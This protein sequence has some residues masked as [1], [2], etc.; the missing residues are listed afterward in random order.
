MGA[1]EAAVD[2]VRKLLAL[3]ESSNANEAAAAAAA[4]QRLMEQHGIDAAML[5]TEDEPD[6]PVAEHHIGDE[7]KRVATWRN[8][9]AYALARANGCKSI[10]RKQQRGPTKLVLIGRAS[11]A[12]VVRYMYRYLTNE[13]DRLCEAEARSRGRAGKTWRT[14]FR[15]GA[16]DV[17]TRRLDEAKRQARQERRMQA[18][19]GV[20]L[21]RV[22]EAI[23]KLDQRLTDAE[24][25]AQ[26]NLR[27]RK[28]SKSRWRNDP[29]AYAAGRKAGEQV[30]LDAGGPGLPS[31]GS[32]GGALPR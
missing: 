21:A 23:A 1:P 5:D 13:I 31:K 10:L 11:D 8:A 6:E 30:R 19:G 29:E 32:G 9:L 27:L 3:S 16:V 26:H 18:G 24:R 28:G 12:A 14:N 15:V 7:G 20:A 4:A 17:I 22:D 25:W 2:R